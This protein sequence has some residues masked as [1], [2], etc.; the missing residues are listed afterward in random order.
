MKAI[1]NRIVGN[2]TM[3][4]NL[5]EE[6]NNLIK[7]VMEPFVMKGVFLQ[8]S[9]TKEQLNNK[10]LRKYSESESVLLNS[11]YIDKHK[12]SLFFINE[13]DIIE[14]NFEDSLDVKSEYKFVSV[15][16]NQYVIELKFTSERVK[17]VKEKIKFNKFRFV[18]YSESKRMSCRI[19]T[20]TSK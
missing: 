6:T 5:I 13:T 8:S 18:Y 3:I 19:L 7:Q 16:A 4:E 17:K 11:D 9:F 14:L 2:T 20:D 12:E 15:S 10:Y 1:L